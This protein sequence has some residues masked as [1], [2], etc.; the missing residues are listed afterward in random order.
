MADADWAKYR[1]MRGKDLPAEIQLRGG[2]YR[3]VAIFKHDFY[4]ATGLYRLVGEP[5]TVTGPAQ[6]VLK[7]YHTDSYFGLPLRWLGRLL[8]RRETRLCE[9][10]AGIE[11]VPRLLERYGASGLV[12]EFVPG[13]NLRET[14]G[15][16]AQFFPRLERILAEVHAR[17]ITH[18]DLSKPENI[19]VKSDGR[20]VLIDFQ[21][22]LD[23]NSRI[24]LLQTVAHWIR[25]YLQ[26]VDRY[27]LCKNH[28]RARPLDFTAQER[29]A[30]R[31]KGIILTMHGWIRVPYRKVRHF[32]LKRYLTAKT[33]DH[34]A[35]A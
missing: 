12:R 25:H 17:G 23:T 3:R 9:A 2:F 4:A 7:I 22:A 35:A 26:G 29:A 21:I 13:C 15:V 1:R 5:S 27:H 10:L 33:T 32:V 16:D 20:P 18:N 24:P 8:C 31:R 11:G 28:R 6:V 19:L 30:S 14:P 34:Q